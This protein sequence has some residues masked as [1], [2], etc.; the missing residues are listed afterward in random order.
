M[1]KK[2]EIIEIKFRPSDD[3]AAVER[4]KV[5]MTKEAWTLLQTSQSTAQKKII[6]TFTKHVPTPGAAPY[7]R[8]PI[9]IYQQETIMVV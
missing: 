1:F 7:D 5:E 3:E 2:L 4:A 9:R 8:G 6:L